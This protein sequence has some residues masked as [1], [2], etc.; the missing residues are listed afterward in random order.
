MSSAIKESAGVRM[1][2]HAK[3]WRTAERTARAR[4][5]DSAFPAS[6]SHHHAFPLGLLC[7]VRVHPRAASI[8]SRQ[9]GQ[10]V[11]LGMG[12]RNGHYVR[13]GAQ[14]R[15]DVIAKYIGG[16]RRRRELARSTPSSG[17]RVAAGKEERESGSASMAVVGGRAAGQGESGGEEERCTAW[18]YTSVGT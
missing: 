18:N 9:A 3:R 6:A 15:E 10:R 8:C 16:S 7:S 11:F 17:R 2:R 4:L 12:A 5:R 1:A 14:G 13:V